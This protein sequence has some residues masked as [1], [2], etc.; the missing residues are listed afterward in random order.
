M[1]S[2]SFEKRI[3]R[4]LVA[5][6]QLFFIA[7]APGL[8]NICLQELKHLSLHTDEFSIVEGG[9]EFKGALH[10]A[11][12][13]N[14]HLRT[15]NRVL[16]RIGFFKATNFRQ[17][18]RNL[19][20]IPWEFFLHPGQDTDIRVVTHRSRL[21]HTGAIV[22]HV[23][24]D[25]RAYFMKHEAV[26][27]T[28]AFS[29]P[30]RIF[31]RAQEDGFV[32][33]IDSSGELLFKRGIKPLVGKAPI[34]ETLAA[35]FL[36]L[37]GYRPDLPLIDPMAGSGT[38]SLEAAMIAQ[39]M[40]P[41]W[42]RDFA[43]MEWPCFRPGRW[44]HLRREAENAFK[45]VDTPRIFAS[46]KDVPVYRRLSENIRNAGFTSIIETKPADFFS[47]HHQPPAG[48][49]ILNPPYG[50]RMG[51]RKQGRIFFR[52]IIRKLQQSFKGWD[53]ALIMPEQHLLRHVPFKVRQ[54]AF[55]HG[56]LRL[57]LLTG[58]IR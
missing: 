42:K 26:G 28:H 46:D 45:R 54:H 51:T 13:A 31:I 56:G 23:K 47:I 17:L 6:P 3:K 7:T 4:R 41:G 53:M 29:Q 21:Y 48:L 49:V 30:Q 22:E 19:S 40:P 14:L 15:A 16:M 25:I 58:R 20:C 18:S 8:E 9:I 50:H 5:R 35:A 11:Y 12:A 52:Q 55:M 10:D 24:N 38:F 57:I 27:R 36:S 39:N 37:A 34:R 32:V 43:F 33:S 1:T 44:R 2:D